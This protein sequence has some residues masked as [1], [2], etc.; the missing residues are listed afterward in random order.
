MQGDDKIIDA[1]ND[2]LTNELTSINQ[3]FIHAKMCESWGIQRLYKKLYAESIG[4]MKHATILIERILYL[5]GVPQ[6]ARY[7]PIRVGKDVPKIFEND[8]KIESAQVAAVNKHLELCVKHNDGGSRELLE[9]I[10]VGS[11]E[12]VD[13]LETQID[14]IEKVGLQNYLAEQLKE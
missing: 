9:R 7:H 13:W 12:H 6:I 5:E 4:E 10:L 14:L 2:I 1:L 8:L 11:E 3:Y